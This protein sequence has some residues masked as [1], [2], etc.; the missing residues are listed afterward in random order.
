MPAG[1]GIS[2]TAKGLN[3]VEKAAMPMTKCIMGVLLLGGLALLGWMVWQVGLTD[4]L[5]SGQVVAAYPASAA[6]NTHL[7]M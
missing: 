1:T 4:L 2:R 5:A 3:R 7:L 6:S